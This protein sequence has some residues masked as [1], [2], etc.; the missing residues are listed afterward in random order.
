MDKSNVEIIYCTAEG[1]RISVEVTNPVKELLEQ[2]DRQIR[3]QRRQDRRHLSYAG[4]A[5]EELDNLLSPSQEDT[6]DL[7]ERKERDTRLHAAIGQ[8]TEVQERRLR[9]YYFDDLSYSQIAR[10]EGVTHKAVMRSI[11]Q[12]LRNLR[13]LF[14]E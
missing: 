3:S 12:A 2:S 5:A 1:K 11:E 10:M 8:L 9:R 7:L 4:I 6:A 14:S 13:T